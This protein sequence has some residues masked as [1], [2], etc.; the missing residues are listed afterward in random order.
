MKIR[1]YIRYI[2]LLTL[3]IIISVPVFAQ[4]EFKHARKGNRLYKGTQFEEAELD[5]RRSIE[6]NSEY[7]DASFN[8]GDALYKQEK[9]EEATKNFSSLAKTEIEPQKIADTYFNLGNAFL[10]SNKLK[11]SIEAYKESLRAFPGSAEAKYNLAYAQD[12]LKKQEQENQDKNQDKDKNKEDEESDQ[13]KDKQDQK[14]E[15]ENEQKDQDKDQ[16]NNDQEKEQ[17]KQNEPQMSK[18]DVERLL[19]ALA[20]DEQEV[21]EKV[22]KEKAAKARVKTLKNW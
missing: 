19:Q 18:E 16:K 20:A 7:I 17:S 21:Q 13:N 1:L 14:E 6:E 2:A 9:F 22:K 10:K 8:L 15:D 12:L 11:E 3:F 5:Y 4:K